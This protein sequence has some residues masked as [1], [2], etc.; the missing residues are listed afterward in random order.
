MDFT[1]KIVKNVAVLSS[2]ASGW[3]KEINV[4]SWNNGEP[5]YDI[6]NW[7]PNHER[8]GK[9]ITLSMDEVGVLQ[10]A[11]GGKRGK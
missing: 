9:G 1:H 5:V 10:A 8:V 3:T 2:A 7:G 11:L 4:V 6:R